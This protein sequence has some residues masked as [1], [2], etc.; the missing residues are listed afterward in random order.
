[1]ETDKIES[2]YN[3]MNEK[4]TAARQQVIEDTL[5]AAN[6]AIVTKKLTPAER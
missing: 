5:S 4:I 2:I 1:M 6:K 3:D